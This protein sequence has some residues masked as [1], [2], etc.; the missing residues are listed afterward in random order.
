M[1]TY[2]FV[3]TDIPIE[4]QVA[5]ACHGALEAGI[6]FSNIL[7]AYPD[8]IVVLGVKDKHELLKA[9]LLLDK[10]EIRFKMFFEPS[11]DYGYTSIG[12]EPIDTDVR[13]YL[14]K[15]KLWKANE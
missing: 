15:F 1:H 11:W 9:A 6:E 14:R 10:H 13:K 8:S 3:R 7:R 5:Q 4:H 12:T 2:I